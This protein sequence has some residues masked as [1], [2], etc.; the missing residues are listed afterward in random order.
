MKLAF[1][2]LGIPAVVQIFLPFTSGVSPLEAVK[3]LFNW[4]SPVYGIGLLGMPFF[5]ALFAL[6]WKVRSYLAIP[7][8]KLEIVGGYGLAAASILPLGFLVV[9]GLLSSHSLSSDEWVIIPITG[10]LIFVWIALLV[11]NIRRQVPST[12]SVHLA[13]LSAYIPNAA[14][15]LWGFRGGWQ[16]GAYLALFAVIVYSIEI[17]FITSKEWRA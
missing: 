17:G 12:A 9:G 1:L 3:E 4:D 15:C 10:F 14:F 5:S 8:K 16:V 6:T 2:I 7:V 11:V 13:L